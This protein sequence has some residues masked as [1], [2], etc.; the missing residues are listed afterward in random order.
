MDETN[1]AKVEIPEP[2]LQVTESAT[3]HT[4]QAL[5]SQASGAA[6]ES[7]IDKG[8]VS[9]EAEIDSS[10]SEM[11]AGSGGVSTK[12]QNAS[13]ETSN[14]RQP[15][16]LYCVPASILDISSGAALSQRTLMIALAKKGFRSVALQ[17]TVFDSTYGGEHVLKAGE[18]HKDKP[19]LRTNTNG[20]EHIIVR[21]KAARRGEMT[22]S[23]QETYLRRFR[24]E[25]A[26]RRPDMVF[27]WGGMLL[28]MTMM[29]EAREA[30]IPVIFYLVNGGYKNKETFR[31]VSTVVTDT[32]ATADLYKQR[33][34]LD[35]KV[36]GK[37]IDPDLIKPKVQRRPDFITFINP[38]FEKGVSVFMPLAKLAAKE[39]P[40]IMFLVVQSRGR[41]SN[42]LHILKFKPEDFPN[43]KV[44][45]HQTDMR[46]VYASTR[47]LLLP[48]LWHESGA[49]VIAE[50]QLNG[51]PILASDTG[52]SAELIGQ[53]GIILNV[54][55]DVREKKTVPAPEEVARAWLNEIK[56]IWYDQVHYEKLCVKVEQE[57]LQHDLM[58]NAERFIKAVGPVVLHSKGLG[59]DGKPLKSVSNTVP[60]IIKGA[61]AK[62]QGKLA[63]RN[64][65]R[66]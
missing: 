18:I 12:V 50:A 61:L 11:P 22:C 10:E 20:V 49:R 47:A 33:L 31:Y 60:N 43:V 59:L 36:V 1:E 39:F 52:G 62:K 28:E 4:I 40:E 34:G 44:I 6:D 25:L 35:C 42:A 5:S 56:K 2:D 26:L 30:G 55:E 53:G 54:P 41:W 66:R 24:E 58:Q 64:K 19:I 48:S 3:A 29:R 16:I 63:A 14:N 45:G 32:R 15:S 57:A 21:T 27:M 7:P 65:K 37:F 23:E 17:A 46:P 9:I 51:I 13:S 38:S 8:E